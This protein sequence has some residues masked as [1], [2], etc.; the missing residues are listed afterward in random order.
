MCGTNDLKAPKLS[1]SRYVSSKLLFAMTPLLLEVIRASKGFIHK[2][3]N[4]HR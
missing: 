2:G 1:N 4:D 3:G